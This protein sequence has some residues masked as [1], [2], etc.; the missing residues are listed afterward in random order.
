MIPDAN[1]NRSNVNYYFL[2]TKIQNPEPQ[3]AVSS[4]LLDLKGFKIEQF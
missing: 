1:Q 4:V 2:D 3:G